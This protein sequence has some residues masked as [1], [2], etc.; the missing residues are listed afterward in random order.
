MLVTIPYHEICVTSNG[1][2]V[3]A[4][5]T[6]GVI[7]WIK[8]TQFKLLLFFN[9]VRGSHS[10]SAL[11][12]WTSIKSVSLIQH[13]CPQTR[14]LKDKV[15]LPTD[16]VVTGN[17]T[18]TVLNRIRTLRTR[19]TS[20]CWDRNGRGHGAQ[21]VTANSSRVRTGLRN[22]MAMAALMAATAYLESNLWID[23]IL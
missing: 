16:R 11:K 1:W 19:Q 14:I 23:I 15:G 21:G 13:S 5:Q 8:N 12:A 9:L 18:C 3:T 6:M 22:W 10:S 7:R 2:S 17:T 4:A 20:S